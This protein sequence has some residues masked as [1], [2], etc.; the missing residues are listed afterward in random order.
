VGFALISMSA[1]VRADKLL[2]SVSRNRFP[3]QR[4]VVGATYRRE[5]QG[6]ERAAHSQAFL[7]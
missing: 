3:A 5:P 2:C 6:E 4:V 1:A 7:D